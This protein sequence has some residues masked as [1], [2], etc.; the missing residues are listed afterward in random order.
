MGVNSLPKKASRLDLNPGPSAPESSTLTTRL[1]S[2]LS[3][4][5]QDGSD[6][7]ANR[8][9]NYVSVETS[10]NFRF[11]RLSDPSY[12]H[13]WRQ[14]S[15]FRNSISRRGSLRWVTNDVTATAAAAE[16]VGS[17]SAGVAV[18]CLKSICR[19]FRQRQRPLYPI[20]NTT[21]FLVLERISR[22]SEAN[23]LTVGLRKFVIIWALNV[24]CSNSSA[25]P[26]NESPIKLF[27][28]SSEFYK[29]LHRILYC[30]QIIA[31]KED[32]L[33]IL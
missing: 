15:L 30:L 27:N 7:R 32:I 10:F 5:T 2:H 12:V 26:K 14:C 19:L 23:T 16:S 6:K 21:A 24:H 33:K 17:C 20:F 18:T 4:V 1:P 25:A 29:Q 22:R 13:P 11:A 3:V 31:S 9:L 28:L 8:K